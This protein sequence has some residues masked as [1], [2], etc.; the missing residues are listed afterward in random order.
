LCLGCSARK[1]I[2][3]MSDW[4]ASFLYM[5][6][7]WQLQYQVVPSGESNWNCAHLVVCSYHVQ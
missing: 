1:S 3:Y 6:R 5:H 7:S 4:S 2:A